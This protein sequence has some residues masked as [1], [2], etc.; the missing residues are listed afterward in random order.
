MTEKKPSTFRSGGNRWNTQTHVSV[1]L[2]ENPLNTPAFRNQSLFEWKISVT[3]DMWLNSTK[4]EEGQKNRKTD[5]TPDERWENYRGWACYEL[6][7]VVVRQIPTY[8]PHICRTISGRGLEHK[9]SVYEP[10]VLWACAWE[11]LS[12]P[13]RVSLHDKQLLRSGMRAG[14]SGK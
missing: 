5:L 7:W 3:A 10:C 9:W 1:F 4:L 8:V 12:G 13:D 11:E 6:C 14:Q 2:W